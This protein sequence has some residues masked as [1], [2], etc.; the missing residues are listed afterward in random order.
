MNA[1]FEMIIIIIMNPV[2]SPNYNICC[3][4]TFFLL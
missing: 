2:K 1:M 3:G 4:L